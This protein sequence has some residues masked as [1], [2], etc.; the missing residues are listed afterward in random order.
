MNDHVFMLH[1]PICLKVNKI[2]IIFSFYRFCVFQIF[3]IELAHTA[4]LS[5]LVFRLLPLVDM[6]RGLILMS[7]VFLIPAFLKT[8]SSLRDNSMSKK[9]R[10]VLFILNILALAVQV[11]SIVAC[12]LTNFRL[13]G[14]SPIQR[15]EDQTSGIGLW[16]LPV[17]LLFVSLSYWENYVDGDVCLGSI[18]IPI[19][20]WKRGIHA[21]R[22]RL[23]ILAS[24]WKISWTVVFAALLLPDFSFNISSS[25]PVASGNNSYIYDRTNGYIASFSP[26][27][28]KT[29]LNGSLHPSKNIDSL[30]HVEPKGTSSSNGEYWKKDEMKSE[31]T[32][33]I[34]ALYTPLIIQALSSL[35][36]GYFGGLACKVC[37]QIIGFSLPLCLTPLVTVALI[38]GHCYGELL[39]LGTY[40]WVCPT[41]NTV[42]LRVELLWLAALYI[43]QIVITSH[44]WFPQT[45]RMTKIDR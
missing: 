21:V 14:G 12:S 8:I 4:G 27:N 45:G 3:V 37:M 40:D 44:V 36:L 10:L 19:L 1:I 29:P 22:Q 2:V 16:E 43:S 13:A 18:T 6:I 20:G 38:V 39:P 26:R 17:A 24:I 7:S 34:L 25:S 32:W 41:T 33:S 35:G 42:S 28:E 11:C 30:K 23:Y 15:N 9:K 5:I 31:S